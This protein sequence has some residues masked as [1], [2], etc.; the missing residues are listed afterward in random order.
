MMLSLVIYRLSDLTAHPSGESER[1]VTL[2]LF[3]AELLAYLFVGNSANIVPQVSGQTPIG[4]STT[5]FVTFA[6]TQASNRRREEVK[7]SFVRIV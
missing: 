2:R 7:S 3:K 5:H 6:V 1:S 4:Q